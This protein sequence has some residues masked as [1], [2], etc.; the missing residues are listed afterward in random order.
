MAVDLHVEDDYLKRKVKDIS[1][2]KP[3]R[4]RLTN[5]AS[6]NVTAFMETDFNEAS[7]RYFTARLTLRDMS[8]GREMNFVI[9]RDE[10]INY[11][12]VI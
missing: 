9:D 4:F 6:N 2:I 8:M 7:K 11:L 5:L 1:V 12:K 3:K 10:L